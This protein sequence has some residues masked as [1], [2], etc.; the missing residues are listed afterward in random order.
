METRSKK[1][2]LID[3]DLNLEY[4]NQIDENN[5]Q[6]IQIKIER[7]ISY[8]GNNMSSKFDDKFFEEAS[9]AWRK[10]KIK[11]KNGEFRYKL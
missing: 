6:N 5:K 4:I 8:D 11:I 10:N 2:K 7:I 3:L 9:N 1:R